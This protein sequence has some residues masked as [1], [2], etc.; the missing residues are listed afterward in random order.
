MSRHL[1]VRLAAVAVALLTAAPALA[2]E[3][4]EAP[5]RGVQS[6][7]TTVER[8]ADQVAAAVPVDLG[9]HVLPILRELD[10]ISLEAS[11][12]RA[13]AAGTVDNRWATRPYGQGTRRVQAWGDAAEV[14]ETD[15]HDGTLRRERL[16]V[17]DDGGVV[18][19][20][21]RG[22]LG[23]MSAA[24]HS[25]GPST[26]IVVE[27]GRGRGAAPELQVFSTQARGKVVRV[28]KGTHA[29][30]DG[31]RDELVAALAGGPVSVGL[32]AR[33]SAAGLELRAVEGGRRR[34]LHFVGE[35]VSPHGGHLVWRVGHVSKK[36]NWKP[37]RQVQGRLSRR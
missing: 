12:G 34:S 37:G 7:R 17:V 4:R 35:T 9:R 28:P 15:P 19:V 36:G 31:A 33:L 10:A 16:A 20:R 11:R 8:I 24:V 13:S 32:E 1:I 23:R 21:V 25:G 3:V 26:G 27:H 30:A 18:G 29:N 22:K 2:N 14:F 5:R 6:L